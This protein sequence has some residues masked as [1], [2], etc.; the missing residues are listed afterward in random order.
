[1]KI[2]INE[3]KL[4]YIVLMIIPFFIFVAVDG[5][6][7][8]QSIIPAILLLVTVDLLNM[9]ISKNKTM[10]LVVSFFSI[11]TISSLLFNMLT[12]NGLTTNQTY[13]RILYYTVI[14]Y[15]YF[16]FLCW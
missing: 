4:K 15:L 11:S 9:K 7:S 1:M 12:N 2:K 3:Q 13:I 6:F 14:L 8:V 10:F 5:I 16:S